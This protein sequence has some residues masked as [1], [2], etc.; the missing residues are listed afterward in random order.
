MKKGLILLVLILIIIEFASGQKMV[1]GC[2]RDIKTNEPLPYATIGALHKQYG[3]YA[4]TS[5]KFILFYSDE[6]DSLIITY[7]GYK[8]INTTI[9]DLQKKANIYLE[10]NTIQLNDVIVNPKKVR[11]KEME[12][13]YFVKKYSML[14]V[15]SYAINIYATFIPFPKDGA[16]VI[17]KSLRF[18]YCLATRNSPLR[19]HILK[20]KDNGEPGDDMINENIIFSNYKPNRALSSSVAVIDISKYNILMPKNGVFIALEWINLDR[21]PVNSLKEAGHNGPYINSLKIR[22]S[23]NSK[24]VNLYNQFNWRTMPDTYTMA[25]GLKVINYMVKK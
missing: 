3:C 21:T 10:S 6:N 5:G 9:K 2:I 23:S 22:N 7:L 19:V 17:M 16:N 4:D 18:S 1:Q 15:P 20:V 12:L 11:K 24:W 13:G 25:I 8:N 14:Q